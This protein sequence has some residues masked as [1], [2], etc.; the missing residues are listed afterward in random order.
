M[1]VETLNNGEQFGPTWQ[2][3]RKKN[4]ARNEIVYSNASSCLGGEENG[5]NWWKFSSSLKFTFH[6]YARLINNTNG[7]VEYRIY[8]RIME[9]KNDRARNSRGNCLYFPWLRITLWNCL[10]TRVK[11]VQGVAITRVLLKTPCTLSEE[12]VSNQ[13]EI[14]NFPAEERKERMLREWRS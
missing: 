12:L 4:S 2:V 8:I 6:S 9:K 7:K 11:R 10:L 14:K 5:G 13:P 3:S 1:F